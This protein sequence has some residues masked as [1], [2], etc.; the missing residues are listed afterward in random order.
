MRE[1]VM[2]DREGLW[3][4][5]I[6]SG[7]VFMDSIVFGMIA[8]IIPAYVTH[9]GASNME[10]GILFSSFSLVVLLLTFPIG[11]LSDYI[12]RK[13]FIIG[14]LFLL[15]FSSL[16]YGLSNSLTL[17]IVSRSLQGL[18]ATF[19]Y[20]VCFAFIADIY[21]PDKRG[22]TM[23]IIGAAVGAGMIAGPMIGGL[24]AEW[25][26]YSFPFYFLAALSAIFLV[27]SFFLLKE[28]LSPQK[29]NKQKS[30]QLRRLFLN[31]NLL[32]TLIVITIVSAGWAIL[33]SLYPRYLSSTS[34]YGMGLMGV[35]FIVSIIIFTP[36]RVISGRISDKIGRKIPFIIGLII[37]TGITPF[38]PYATNLFP[39]ILV[40][41]L[42]FFAFG[43][44][45]GTTMPLIAD[46]VTFSGYQDDP[47]GSA[48]GMYNVSWA[49]GFFFGPLA[50]G[51]IVDF[52]NIKFLFLLY[53]S[54]LA[55]SIL[56]AMQ[57]IIEPKELN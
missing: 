22:T 5:I 43:M 26:S 57:Y 37:L 46:T 1:G 33:E 25:V 21:P 12:G 20:S 39:I 17:L 54:F 10:I 56:I 52:L 28:P 6:I 55:A 47:Y 8:P 13:P 53:T 51:A 34:G 49:I 45:F 15:V 50:G 41:S 44:I 38:V 35:L 4:L 48:S 3:S 16:L 32:A 7:C 18:A 40:L 31:Q 19:T 36:V 27:P 30:I 29:E 14:G 24:L 2:A 42:F 23:G 9:L 11:L